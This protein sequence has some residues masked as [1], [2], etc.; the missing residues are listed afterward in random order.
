MSDTEESKKPR[1]WIE[2]ISAL[3]A[4]EPKN[5]DELM[6]LLRAAQEHDILSSEMFEMMERIL[7]VSEMQVREVMVPKAQMVVIK[8]SNKLEELLP[9][10]IES[11]HSRFPVTD[12]DGK[13]V[14]GMLLAKDLLPYCFEKETKDFLMADIMRPTIFTSQSKRLDIL[15]REFRNNRNH[16][17]IVLDEY[18]HVAGLVTIEDV[19][20]QIVGEIED[21]YD[22]DEDNQDLIRKLDSKTYIVKATTTIEEFNDYFKT[23]LSDEEFDTI[24]GI[25]LSKFGRFPKRGERIKLHNYRF[26]VLQSDSRRIYLL[27]VKST[28]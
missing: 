23:R 4:R 20:E 18:A 19:L 7:Q 17:A 21:E 8:H 27:E 26:K 10:V 24:G 28:K 13:E 6:E 11:G 22:I 25:V 1:S 16:I 9:L 14:L 12:N 3:L 15:L 2:R 5:R